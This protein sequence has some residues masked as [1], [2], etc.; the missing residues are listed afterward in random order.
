MYLGSEWLLLQQGKR[1]SAVIPWH[2]LGVRNE[3]KKKLSL[4]SSSTTVGTFRAI[5]LWN[6]QY[7]HLPRHLA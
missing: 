2:L 7:N 3:E 1:G 4:S 5:N 6:N